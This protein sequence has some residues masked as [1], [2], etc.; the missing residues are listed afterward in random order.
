MLPKE[1]K[2]LVGN[3]EQFIKK[4][5]DESNKVAKYSQRELTKIKENASSLEIVIKSLKSSLQRE[6]GAVKKLSERAVEL[7]T[8][9]AMAQRTNDTHAALQHENIA[10]SRYF[11]ELIKEFETTLTVY[12]AQI[13]NLESHLAAG[14]ESIINQ[15]PNSLER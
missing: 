6:G 11:G 7:H 14:N 9:V 2:D 1:I 8:G 10:P 5:K 15:L 4:E 3:L 13:D 12:R